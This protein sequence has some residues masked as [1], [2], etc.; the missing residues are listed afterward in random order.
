MAYQQERR[1]IFPAGLADQIKRCIGVLVI[2]IAGRFIREHQFGTIRQ[3]ARHRHALLL[4]GGKLT[5]IMF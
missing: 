1:A 4:A 5:G 2:K 3:G